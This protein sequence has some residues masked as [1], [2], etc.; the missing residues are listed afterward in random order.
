MH[1]KTLLAML[2]SGLLL[3]ACSVPYFSGETIDGSGTQSTVVYDVSDFDALSVRADL[4]VVVEIV[5]GSKTLVEITIDDNL[6]EELD[7]DVNDGALI[8]QPEADKL[9]RH[10]KQVVVR[11]E[12]QDLDKFQAASD[13]R[14]T[15]E[16]PLADAIRLEASSDARILAIVDVDKLDISARSDGRID[17]T[18]R[19]DDLSVNSSSDAVVRV[20]VDSA[21]SSIEARSD[22]QIELDGTVKQVDVSTSSDASVKIRSTQIVDVSVEA[23]SDSIIE[24]SASGTVTGQARSDSKMRVG[25]DAR[26]EVTK[27]SDGTIER[28]R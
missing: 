5:D 25:G 2:G 26:V 21:R 6:H 1:L 15:V 10:T 22:S 11:I 16:A 28:L 27:S 19:A 17:V 4:D 8:I 24:V 7:V 12:G 20:D 13:S 18:G 9:L 23:S 3:S 14:L